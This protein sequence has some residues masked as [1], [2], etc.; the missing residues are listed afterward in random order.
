MAQHFTRAEELVVDL[1]DRWSKPEHVE[2]SNGVF[3]A[4]R[5]ERRHL[6]LAI[7]LT[8]GDFDLRTFGHDRSGDRILSE[9][10][11][12][13]DV[14]VGLEGHDRLQAFGGDQCNGLVAFEVEVV[15]HR[16]GLIHFGDARVFGR[17]VISGAQHVDQGAKQEAQQYQ[18]DDQRD[19]EQ[20]VALPRVV[21][22][23][24]G[25]RLL[26]RWSIL[27]RR[28]RDRYR[29]RGSLSRRRLDDSWRLRRG[30]GLLSWDDLG[31]LFDDFRGRRPAGNRSDYRWRHNG[32]C[33]L[34][35]TSQAV[36][37]TEVALQVCGK[38]PHRRIP[39]ARI[40]RQRLE[41]DRLQRLGNVAAALAGRSWR[42]L[43]ML[44]G[45]LGWRVANEWRNT[46]QHLVQHNG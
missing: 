18:E 24:S 34:V 35:R 4:E 3:L 30:L 17:Q 41:G 27:N 22:A 26:R 32:G 11:T 20:D 19:E 14:S 29:F 7:G 10:S 40:L 21:G 8:D 28:R 9:H 39:L 37:S 6:D 12:F 36:R 5:D 16:D 2:L 33:G 46:T 38:V 23:A 43:H 25:P 45:D 31:C 13:S 1:L 42:L 15:G 44:A